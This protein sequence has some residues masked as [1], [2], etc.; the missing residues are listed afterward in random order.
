SSDNWWGSLVSN[1]LVTSGNTVSIA[2]VSNWDAKCVLTGGLCSAMGTDA[3]GNPTTTIAAQ[4]PTARTLLTWDSVGGKASPLEWASLT[5]AQQTALNST[6]GAGANRLK[7]LRGDRSTEQLAS[8]TPGNLRARTAV[9]GDIINSSP[10]WVGAPVPGTNPDVFSDGLYGSSVVQPENQS[11]AQAYSNFA[12]TNATRLNVVYVGGN[13][14]FLHGFRAGAY[15]AAGNYTPTNVH[16]YFVDATPTAVDLFYNNA[17]HTWLVGGVGSGGK[18]V[19]ALDITN[20][21]N[22]SQSTASSVVVGDWTSA[23]TGLSHL[24]QT[25]GSPIIS[26][27]HNGQWAI[28]FGN[29][30]GS[31]ASAGVYIGLV[32]S[33]TGA[34][35]FQF[36]DTGVGSPTSA[37]GIAY[38]SQGDLDGDNIT[39]Y[40]YAGDLQG[41]V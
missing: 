28:I 25:V 1:S 7:W 37:N 17:W 32:D 19:Y 13:D 18:E 22:F 11:G 39:D 26:R 2:T 5:T 35:T 16:G 10:T 38:V 23:T 30:L 3:Q 12:S 41:N 8:P 36:L 15:D 33:S 34:V 31:G 29:G 9:L 20:P 24:G 4:G 21:G 14:G 27:M 40:L 6:D